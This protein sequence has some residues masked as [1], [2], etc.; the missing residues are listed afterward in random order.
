[1]ASSPSSS[2][3]SSPS[4]AGA[5]PASSSYWCYNCD[6]FV[7]ATPH[8]DSAVAYPNYGGGI[9][10][11]MGAPP[12]R[13]AYLRHPCAHHAKDLCLRRTCC[14]DAAAAADDRS[15]FNPVIVLCR[16]PTV[17]ATGDDDSLAT[18]YDS[19][20]QNLISRCHCIEF[21]RGSSSE[22]KTSTHVRCSHVLDLHPAY[23]MNLRRGQ[24]TIY[25]EVHHVFDQGIILRA[26]DFNT[27]KV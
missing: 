24:S 17:V 13:T 27:R 4:A 6:P 26:Y 10:E 7:R 11:E 16:S 12:P 22:H 8:D 1:M 3:S 14:A 20:T 15:P 23:D 21:F 9:L 2:F 25:K 5:A 19:F 18:W